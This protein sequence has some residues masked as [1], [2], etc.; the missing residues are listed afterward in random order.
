MGN[1]ASGDGG[2]LYN[3]SATARIVNGVFYE[4]ASLS[5]DG[6]GLYNQG[7]LRLYHNPFNGNRALGGDGGAIYSAGSLTL[8]SSIVY[9]NSAQNAAV[10]AT[11]PVQ[12]HNLFF[13]NSPNDASFAL[14]PAENATG[15]WVKV[16]QR[17]PVRL[18]LDEA[19]PN[20]SGGLSATAKVDVRSALGK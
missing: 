5:G 12:S 18:A 1:S 14:L 7:T 4:N 10:V 15:N 8:N 9:D 3:A 11:A 2:G 16:V 20:L 17:L 19:A 6:A 13:A